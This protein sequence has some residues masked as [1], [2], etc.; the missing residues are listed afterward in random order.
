MNLLKGDFFLNLHNLKHTFNFVVH[1]ISLNINE[2]RHFIQKFI[3]Y[4]ACFKYK[5]STAAG[6][7]YFQ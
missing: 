4:L 1:K 7:F 6:D 3:N 2:N 5:K